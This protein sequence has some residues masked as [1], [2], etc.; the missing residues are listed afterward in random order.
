[1]R[2]EHNVLCVFW[3]RK[4]AFLYMDLSLELFFF[5]KL[6]TVWSPERDWS[7][8]KPRYVTLLDPIIVW[9]PQHWSHGFYGVFV[10]NQKQCILSSR[11]EVT[12]YCPLT[13][14]DTI[15]IPCW[16]FEILLVGPYV[17]QAEHYH[18]HKEVTCSWLKFPCRWHNRG[19]RGAQGG[20]PG[21]LRMWHL[22]ILIQHHL[23]WQ[24]VDDQ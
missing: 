12:A 7:R 20:F 4:V 16:G 22:F 3:L 9:S 23:H 17:T 6:W 10:L 11:D 8:L 1:M 19:T 2:A 5:T 24:F 13:I 14:G 15:L 18:P 21:E